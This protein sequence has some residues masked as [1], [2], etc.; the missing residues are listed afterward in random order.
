MEQKIGNITIKLMHNKTWL[1]AI[2]KDSEIALR[3]FAY[4]AD[5]ERCFRNNL[6][7]YRGY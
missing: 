7:F 6:K 1:V 2:T 5:A 4:E 3:Q